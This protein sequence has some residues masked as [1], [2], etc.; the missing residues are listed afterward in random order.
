MWIVTGLYVWQGY[1]QLGQALLAVQMWPKWSTQGTCLVNQNN[2]LALGGKL[3]IDLPFETYDLNM[4]FE[5]AGS[6]CYVTR[7]L[8]KDFCR[9]KSVNI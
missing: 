8:H 4:V 1:T 3:K 9:G 7:K 5:Q 2:S 6:H